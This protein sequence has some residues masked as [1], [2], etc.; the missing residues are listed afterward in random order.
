MEV[1]IPL[2]DGLA[3]KL[4]PGPSAGADYPTARLPRG[5]LLL[6]DGQELTE[7]GVGFGVPLLK[8]GIRTIFPGSLEYS[9]TRR[10]ARVEVSAA[11]KLNLEEKLARPGGGV[12][13]SRGPAGRGLYALK[14]FLAA[15]IRRFTWLRGPLTAASNALRGLSGWQTAFE[16]SDFCA[17][18]RLVY[19]ID[20]PAG[21]V[22]IRVDASGLPQAGISEIIVM[23]EQGA[24]HFDQYRDSAG[25]SLSGK[26]IG[27][28]DEV[29]A[30]E[31]SFICQRHRLAFS[32]HQVE[33]ATLYRGR[34]LIGSRL[35]WAGFG[36]SFPPGS[37]A[38]HYQVR[39]E[40]LS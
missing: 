39:I 11:F 3:L 22:K 5:L 15:L 13:G 38:Y 2:S 9:A 12:V 10:G 26:E 24:R 30:Q 31:A 20:S 37:E 21:L 23:N 36:Y 35:A 40:R 18:V 25:A 34:E 32:L 6:H 27:C 19:T 16:Q 17:I 33:G 8:R 14:N 29:T 4:A 7:E 28:W 1:I